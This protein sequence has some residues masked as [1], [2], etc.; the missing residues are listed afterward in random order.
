MTERAST[1]EDRH[2]FVTGGATGIGLAI[3]RRLAAA[4]ARVTIASRNAERVEAA[5][6]SI[7]GAHAVILDVADPGSVA[8]AFE[9]AG[10]VDILVNNAGIAH[11]APIHRTSLEQWQQMIAVN[12]TGVFL[13][14]QAVLDHMR[15][16]DNG[17]IVNIASTAGLTGYAYTSGYSAAKHGVVG[18]TR[19]LALE[20][21]KTG[22]TVNSVCPGFTDTDIVADAVT[23]IVQ[24]TGRPE[25]EAL[26]E[27]LRH[28]PQERLVT[29]DEVAHT[30]LWLCEPAS[31][32]ITGQAIAVAGG[33][34]MQ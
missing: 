7:D 20:L 23:N 29:P 16:Q 8:A 2:A 1:L 24:K 12:L 27:L 28:N 14:T 22:I 17:R 33:E 19:S 6:Q 10:P 11:A 30:V 15:K 3:S 4:G 18:L 5:A 32:S 25:A 26:A 13:C 21:A 9:A 34:V 31:R